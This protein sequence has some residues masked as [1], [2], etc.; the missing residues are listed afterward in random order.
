MLYY[1]YFSVVSLIDFDKVICDISGTY[2]N[3]KI[4]ITNK[5]QV[6]VLYLAEE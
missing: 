6:V 4:L 5:I 1:K 2:S 3:F